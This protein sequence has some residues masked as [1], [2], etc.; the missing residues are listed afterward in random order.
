MIDILIDLIVIGVIVWFFKTRKKKKAEQTTREMIAK[1]PI[2]Q[3]VE[4]V[5]DEAVNV[6]NDFLNAGTVVGLFHGDTDFNGVIYY[7]VEYR[8]SGKS[9]I[10]VG[11][12]ETNDL[13]I[14]ATKYPKML[15]NNPSIAA[16]YYDFMGSYQKCY[17]PTK[18]A[19]IY[20]TFHTVPLSNT[21]AE[22]VKQ[23]LKQKIENECPLADYSGDILYNKSVYH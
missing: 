5:I 14:D 21:Q 16:Q 10:L 13:S 1:M 2:G 7:L 6:V 23:R 12:P 15:T 4:P 19:Y 20:H 18:K 8:G 17:D 3:E 22:Q 11:M 9:G